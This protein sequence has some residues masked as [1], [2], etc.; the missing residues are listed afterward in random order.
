MT[1]GPRQRGGAAAS[2]GGDGA[3][4][5]GE[6]SVALKKEI[7]L[8]SACG[9]II[10]KCCIIRFGL[11]LCISMVVLGKGASKY[12]SSLVVV[13]N[14]QSSCLENHQCVLENGVHKL[15][16]SPAG[17]CFQW[18]FSLCLLMVTCS[19]MVIKG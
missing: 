7:G 4:A 12:Y 16:V 5:A 19:C 3:E 2:G 1:D 13:C 11:T 14:R 18:S 8:V 9:I 6:S 17:R 15:W 10:G